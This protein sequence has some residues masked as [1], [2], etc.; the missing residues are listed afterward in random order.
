MESIN[1]IFMKNSFMSYPANYNAKQKT[2]LSLAGKDIFKKDD[3]LNKEISKCLDILYND[4]DK[5]LLK[6][7]D[8]LK[9]R[10]AYSPIKT[11]KLHFG[12]FYI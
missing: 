6:Q 5:N 9:M 12:N 1:S 11:Q 2:V 3:G 7:T 8:K 4:T 10:N